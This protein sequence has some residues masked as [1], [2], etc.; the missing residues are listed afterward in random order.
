VSLKSLLI[1]IEVAKSIKVDK[2]AVVPKPLLRDGTW[3]LM[4]IVKKQYY[5]TIPY[6]CFRGWKVY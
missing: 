5:S 6:C 1:V 2:G 4:T 3:I